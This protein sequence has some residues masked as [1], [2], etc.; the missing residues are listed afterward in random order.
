MR[1]LS[2]WSRSSVLNKDSLGNTEERC[3]DIGVN[4]EHWDNALDMNS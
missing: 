3:I 2:H 4:R 1:L